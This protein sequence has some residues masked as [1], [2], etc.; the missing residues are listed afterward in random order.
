VSKQKTAK[1]NTPK[2][3]HT[4]IIGMNE[5]VAAFRDD[6]IEGVITENT[7]GNYVTN[8]YGGKSVQALYMAGR[9]AHGDRYECVDGV[10]RKI[11]DGLKFFG[12]DVLQGGVVFVAVES[13]DSINERKEPMLYQLACEFAAS[14]PDIIALSEEIARHSDAIHDGVFLTERD[15]AKL[16]DEKRVKSI[17]KEIEKR[18]GELCSYVRAETPVKIIQ[19][20]L[21]DL[22]SNDHAQQIAEDINEAG[23]QIA[24]EYN[25]VTRFV[26]IDS[27]TEAFGLDDWNASAQ[28]GI[29]AKRFAELRDSIAGRPAVM[30]L[31]HFGKN[32]ERG[33]AG[34]YRLFQG[35][36]FDLEG[37]EDGGRRFLRTK[38]IK[39]GELAF[40][41]EFEIC[42]L[43]VGCTPRGKEVTR[44]YI[45][46]VANQVD[47]DDS[48][49]KP[50]RTH[51]GL[52]A[53]KR[54]FYDAGGIYMHVGG[55][56]E[57]RLCVL[58]SNLRNAFARFY[59]FKDADSLDMQTRQDR[60]RTAFNSAVKKAKD[61]WSLEENSWVPQGSQSGKPMDY[62]SRANEA[63]AEV[64]PKSK[65]KP[66][67][68]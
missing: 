61:E 40:N 55:D 64:E 59:T 13:P 2:P 58:K 35:A 39:D 63:E 68:S 26:I 3:L 50:G 52:E 38:K 47:M 14:N 23:V 22:V 67:R 1:Q 51:E 53:L 54:A 18:F 44:P 11:H 28:G 45:L 17:Q 60:L 66:K 6:L 31:G 7:T 20:P 10:Y 33:Q 36:E 62:F 4:K 43:F 5:P 8:S 12:C 42:G 19:A 29:I 41:V 30:G 57:E 27:T 49:G 56:G 46:E 21:L 9:V 34:T 15:R 16:M 32:H 25:C 48:G 24:N 37:R 65:P